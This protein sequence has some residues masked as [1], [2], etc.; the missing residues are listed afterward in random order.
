M[1]LIIIDLVFKCFLGYCDSFCVNVSVTGVLTISKT[2]IC[3]YV[4]DDLCATP[5][6]APTHYVV[7]RFHPKRNSC[8]PV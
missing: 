5:G 6:E 4:L 7:L 1:G 8:D 3:I 2:I